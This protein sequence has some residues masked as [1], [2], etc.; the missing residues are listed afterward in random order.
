MPKGASAATIS[1][2]VGPL[3]VFTVVYFLLNSWIITLAISL[4]K[5][6]S[7]RVWRDNFLR[8]SLNYFGGAS[9]AALLVSYTKEL[10]YTYL[11][12]IVPSVVV[13]Y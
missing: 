12:V 9:V 11:A 3:L 13:L 2:L 7:L 5:N 1:A 4:E 6:A 8:L 10:D